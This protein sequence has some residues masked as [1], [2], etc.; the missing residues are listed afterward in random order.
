MNAVVWPSSVMHCVSKVERLERDATVTA[1]IHT[2]VVVATPSKY[3]TT[4]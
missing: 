3:T 2:V 1:H 4:L